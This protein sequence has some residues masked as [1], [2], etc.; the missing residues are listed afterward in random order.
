MQKVNVMRNNCLVCLTISV[1]CAFF[2][3]AH[4]SAQDN[5]KSLMSQNYS[6]VSSTQLHE[7][8]DA[9]RKKMSAMTSKDYLNMYKRLK[10][11]KDQFQR[12]L[13]SHSENL[14]KTSR[15]EKSL[16]VKELPASFRV[17]AEYE[18]LQAVYI[19][20]PYNA[21]DSAGNFV[22]PFIKGYA[23]E[24]EE[25]PNGDYR[26][27]IITIQVFE[28]DVEDN[29]PYANTWMKLADAIQQEVQVWIQIHRPQDSVIIKEFMASHNT[30]LYNY[31][32]MLKESWGNAFWMRDCG[33][34]GFYYGDND[35]L[36]FL[37]ASYYPGRPLDDDI[38]SFI[39]NKLGY[40]NFK[41]ELEIEGGNFMT[42]GHGTGFYSD[43]LFEN[44]ND[45]LGHG[46]TPKTPIPP[47]QLR[48]TIKRV[49]G[50]KTP[51][52]LRALQC[53]GGT[54]HIDIY[55]KIL[56]DNT[57]AVTEYPKVMQTPQ[58]YDYANVE[59]NL[60]N[61]IATAIAADGKPFNIVRFP[62]P[63]S[64]D[65]RYDSITCESFNWDARGFINGLIMNNTYIFPSFSDANSGNA[66][67]DA[68]AQSIYERAL[69]GYR[70][71]PIDSR[72]LTPL[73]GAIHCI[74]MQIP[75]ENPIKFVHQPLSRFVAKPQ[76]GGFNIVASI[77]NHS[78]VAAS[79]L[80]W[81]KSTDQSFNDVASSS[82]DAANF[83]GVIPADNLKD[84]D[85][86]EY[87]FT[88][89]AKNGRSAKYPYIAP[90][91]LFSFTLSTAN[92]ANNIESDENI[93]EITP[94]PTAGDAVCKFS[95]FHAAYI[96][97]RLTDM[98]GRTVATYYQ[99]D[100]NAGVNSFSVNTQNLEKGIY[101]ATLY[102]NGLSIKT[103]W[104]A[105]Q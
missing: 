88:A 75:A 52:E 29:S 105:V 60:K 92:S 23:L 81:R 64:D 63:T 40:Q 66:Q 46:L 1:L 87:Y 38:P 16:S 89:A 45:N 42:D 97:M 51:I 76:Q 48:D 98:L 99:N 72:W 31:R 3:V 82:S 74:T 24:Y 102:A 13:V 21:F 22:E 80:H 20:W 69:P 71:I 39:A 65:G 27:K 95:L 12:Y 28:P 35:S 68:Q 50:L 9:I 62:L 91:R 5:D 57:I 33:P 8:K 70:I 104:A 30:P 25:L 47:A 19:A 84:G 58:F 15:A 53:D 94:N 61:K 103:L 59:Y 78:G 55:T 10:M 54:T 34:H 11:R 93:F 83:S 41:T 26:P 77:Y 100:A 49:F 85:I 90:T 36:A 6:L 18:E 56:N 96:E 32:F 17:P 37:D 67:L 43:G 79:A 73:G 14:S 101:F 44:N 4:L 7:Q 2:G 86:I